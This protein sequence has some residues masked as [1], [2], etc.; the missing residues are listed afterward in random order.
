MEER[1]RNRTESQ[2]VNA[3]L[4]A[5]MFLYLQWMWNESM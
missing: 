1:S 4:Y 3:S 5:R 2:E